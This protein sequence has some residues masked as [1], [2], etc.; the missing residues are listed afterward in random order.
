MTAVF[1]LQN[2]HKQL[3]SKQGEWVD[4]REVATLYRSVHRDEA[5]NL[6]IETNT[7]DYTLRMQILECAVN[8]RGQPLI[9]DKDLPS[10]T[11]MAD[12]QAEAPATTE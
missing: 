11:L 12:E 5:L 6:M 2:Q 1:L 3:L 10:L 4:G 8:E 7:R 9:E